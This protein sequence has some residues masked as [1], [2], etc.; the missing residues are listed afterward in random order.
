MATNTLPKTVFAVDVPNHELLKLAYEAY[1]AEART[2]AASTKKRGEVRGGGRKPHKQKGTGRARAG[3]IRS[4][5]WRGGGVTFGPSGNENYKK[6]LNVKAK[7]VAVR[8]ALTLAA[9]AGKIITADVSATGKTKDMTAFLKD[10]KADVRRTLLVVSE[11]SPELIRATGNLQNIE[12]VRATYLSVFHVLNA[13]KIIMTPT[14]IT[15][16][17]AWLGKENA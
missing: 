14:A 11:K 7:R 5:L 3:S 17:E 13:D 6:Q 1:L 12:L 8:Q 15:A 9:Q 2:S 16:I 10:Q 4:P